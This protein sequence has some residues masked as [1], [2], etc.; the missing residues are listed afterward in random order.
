MAW[1][2][3]VPEAAA[4]FGL[5]PRLAFLWI[6]IL[7]GLKAKNPEMVNSL[8]GLLYPLTMLSNAFVA[9][10]LMPGWLG[11]IADWNPLSST[12]TATRRLFGNPGVEATGWLA[13]H[14][15]LMAVLG[16]LL[17]TAL[18]LPLAVRAYQRLSR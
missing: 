16:P 11:A 13:D 4:A 2:G 12:I 3:T 1:H 8:Y 17:I 5:L 6:G 18:T 14:A 9:T 10:S 7:F 15:V